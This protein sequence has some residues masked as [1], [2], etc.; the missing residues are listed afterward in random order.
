MTA[1]LN[2]VVA[3]DPSRAVEL[4]RLK[5]EQNPKEAEAYYLGLLKDRPEDPS[6]RRRLAGLYYKMA[7]D[8]GKR[9][10]YEE[11][12][13]LLRKSKDLA[14]VQGA[15]E[16]LATIEDNIAHAPLLPVLKRAEGLYARGNFAEA[17]PIYEQTYQ[18]WPRSLILV[19]IASC[20]MEMGRRE[21]ALRTLNDAAEKKPEDL[22]LTEAVFTY[23]LNQ[24]ELARAEKGFEGIL[25]QHE[26]VYYSL[27]KRG[28]IEIQK[29][30]YA[31]AQEF[32]NRALIYR[33]EFVEARIARG[34]A[35]YQAGQRDSARLDFEEAMNEK[36][37]IGV[38]NFGMVHFNDNMIDQA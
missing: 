29:K 23:Y 3:K 5:E 17:L 16:A 12:R 36:S 25:T 35:K 18:K 24:G 37:E 19:K 1:R 21:E 13:A 11:A 7:L 6:V 34:V 9:E 27:Y 22:E 14:E 4:G 8:A 30:Q 32:F 2:D 33:P 10:K 20:K 31:A 28:I 15:D 38:L 26:D